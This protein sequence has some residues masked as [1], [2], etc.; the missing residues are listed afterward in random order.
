[1]HNNLDLQVQ[2]HE[3]GSQSQSTHMVGRHRAWQ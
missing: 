2:L 3:G 1:M